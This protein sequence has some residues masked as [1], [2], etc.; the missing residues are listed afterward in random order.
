MQ[1]LPLDT[2]TYYPLNPG[3]IHH[4]GTVHAHKLSG[5]PLFCIARPSPPHSSRRAVIL[6]Y[7]SGLLPSAA[8][9]PEP[10]PHSLPESFVKIFRIFLNHFSVTSN[11]TTHIHAC[12]AV[13][14]GAAST[15]TADRSAVARPKHS[16]STR[17]CWPHLLR[18]AVCN[19]LSC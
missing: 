1:P 13:H 6:L 2:C 10:W 11:R 5:W 3:I 16:G 4:L 15:A 9:S 12:T 8:V 7:R 17:A 14:S 18:S 19:V